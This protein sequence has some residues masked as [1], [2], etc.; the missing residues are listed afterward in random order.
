MAQA[1]PDDFADEGDYDGQRNLPSDRPQS[2]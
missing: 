2:R 1:P